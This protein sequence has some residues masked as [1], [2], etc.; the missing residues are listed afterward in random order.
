M[1]LLVQTV[2]KPLL[3]KSR[4]IHNLVKI[5]LV[6]LSVILISQN[7]DGQGKHV[8]LVHA[9]KIAFNKNLVNG[10]RLIGHV[11][12][13]FDGT[14]FYCD[15]AY[16]FSNG[17]FQAFG[18]I[19]VNKPGEYAISGKKL[20]FTEATQSATLNENCVF[21]DGAMTLT[22]P[23]MAYNMKSEVATYSGGGKV[24]SSK[25][26]NELVSQTG[27]YHSPSNNFTF[28]R[29]VTVK[30]KD[31]T[32]VSDT[33]LYNTTTE[34]SYFFGP[35]TI[36]GKDLEIKCENGFF[37]S[38]TETCSFKKNA[39]VKSKEQT[40]FGDSIFY[41]GKDKW[42]EAFQNVII[43]DNNS[44]LTIRGNYG[45]HEETNEISWVTG[46]SILEKTLENKDTLFI[47]ADTLFAK[48]TNNKNR[49]I[50]AYH[51]VIL[52]SK[53]LQGKCDSLSLSEA[54][55]V[56]RMFHSPVLWN[57][58]NQLTGTE[59]NLHF[60]NDSLDFLFVPEKSF[61]ASE[62]VPGYFNQI[63]G[64]SLHGQFVSNDLHEVHIMGN[65]QL[66]YFSTEEKNKRTKLTGLNRTDCS[67]IR[68]EL[69]EKAI[70]KVTLEN[71]PNS[72]YNSIQKTKSS[73][74]KLEDF[75]WRGNE[76]PNSKDDLLK[77]HK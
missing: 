20:F 9:D 34:I 17:N 71:E 19:R 46:K 1:F 40:L 8:Q 12:L 77:L 48:K 61:L 43:V 5:L 52:Y 45:R 44:D 49:D 59:I 47:V 58:A 51:N 74:F 66:A 23:N 76:R 3:D 25:N 4:A 62:V 50:K 32:V 70:Q 21:S 63:K 75:I 42:G 55:S 35:T 31:Y 73:Q 54:D 68:I 60:K 13:N 65:G 6:A 24:V 64:K 57:D 27:R 14:D 15:S 56:M 33:M 16:K 37:N 67:N 29:K 39:R 53:D 26:N 69:K 22:S 18:N 72:L 11:H 10:Q 36:T 41:N 2:S 30:N 7:A 38:K 28:R